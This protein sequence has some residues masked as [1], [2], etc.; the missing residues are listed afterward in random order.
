MF[1][2]SCRR[3][4]SQNSIFC[5]GCGKQL[6]RGRPLTITCW[7]C[8]ARNPDDAIFCWNCGRRLRR[9]D[10][11]ADFILPAPPFSG[12]T[13]P[14]AGNVPTVQGIP[15]AGGAPMVHGTP[16]A[17]DAPSVARSTG[18]TL[19]Q[20]PA[21]SVGQPLSQPAASSARVSPSQSSPAP[22][23][24]V[25]TSHGTQSPRAPQPSVNTPQT[26]PASASRTNNA[27]AGTRA[28]RRIL[29]PRVVLAVVC[30]A[31]VVVAAATIGSL[32][33]GA[34]NQPQKPPISSGP[35]A[36]PTQAPIATLTQ[37][38]TPPPTDTPT[39]T[40]TPSLTPVPVPPRLEASLTSINGISGNNS[41]CTHPSNSYI[42]SSCLIVLSSPGT[43]QQNI[44]WSATLS[45]PRSSAG[46]VYINPSNG[47]LAPGQQ[48]NVYLSI[49]PICDGPITTETIT[50]TGG[51]NPVVVQWTC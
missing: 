3:A 6:Q 17:F 11:A 19:S 43:N 4:I 38:P 34:L 24:P 29:R 26:S 7:S 39:P 31:V 35:A 47:T 2:I 10:S 23:P 37:Q 48:E 46:G 12:G 36:N 9:E 22:R 42:I 14:P 30:A 41:D 18:H 50:F 27:S 49:N 13:Q 8:Q 1:C 16:S 44:N 33:V 51:A 5:P 32:A 15:Q 45:G 25:R 40:P 28:S 21:S 20:T